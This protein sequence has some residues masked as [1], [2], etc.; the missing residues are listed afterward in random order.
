MSSTDDLAKFMLAAELPEGHFVTVVGEPTFDELGIAIEALTDVC[1]RP[2]DVAVIEVERLRKPRSQRCER[3][4]RSRSTSIT[5][6]LLQ[7]YGIIQ[8][9][10]LVY[11]HPE[12]TCVCWIH[13][14]FSR[15][16]R[17]SRWL[18]MRIHLGRDARRPWHSSPSC[19]PLA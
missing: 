2:P 12:N 7:H 1:G 14:A 8:S 10:Y 17:T 9:L 13:N 16:R 4:L 11:L 5:M 15:S 6:F 18:E 19:V 3:G